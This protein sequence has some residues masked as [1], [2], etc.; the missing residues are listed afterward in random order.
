MRIFLPKS[1]IAWYP[2]VL[3][4]TIRYVVI[5]LLLVCF[6]S[7]HQTTSAGELLPASIRLDRTAVSSPLSGLICATPSSAGSGTEEQISITFPTT[8]VI[9]TTTA[10][11]TT[12][13][14]N[15][16][17][18][19]TPW[20]GIG[21]QA[22]SISGKTVTFASSDLTAMNRYCFTF[23]SASSNT[24]TAS[25]HLAGVIATRTAGGT[26]I[27]SKGYGLTIGNDSVT[28]TA[29]VPAQPTDFEADL[30]K[31]APAGSSFHQNQT[32]QYT[33]TYGSA[34]TYGTNITV[35]AE[36]GLGTVAGSGSPSVDILDYVVGSATEAI[37]STPP[38]IDTVNRTISW[39]LTPM[40]GDTHDQTVTFKLKTN[41]SYTGT[42]IVTFP[43]TARVIGPGTQTPD[44]TVTLSYTYNQPAT[45]TPGPSNTPT[46]G[47]SSSITPV[48][49]TSSLPFQFQDIDMAEISS[50]SASIEVRSSHPATFTVSY[51][52]SPNKLTNRFTTL[53][54]TRSTLLHLTGLELNTPYYFRITADDGSRTVTSDIYTFV[55]PTTADV[56][57]FD[58]NSFVVT[59]G[60]AIIFNSSYRKL[61]GGKASFVLPVGT[62]YTIQIAQAGRDHL[63]R[64]QAVLISNSV[65]GAATEELP[66]EEYV[67]LTEVRPGIYVGQ[68]QTP[69]K[70]IYTLSLRAFGSNGSIILS[71][72]AELRSTG[73]LTVVEKDT[74][75]P[76]EGATIRLSVYNQTTK[77][78]QELNSRFS[79][80]EYPI[81]TDQRGTTDLVLPPGTYRAEV[82]ALGFHSETVDLTIGPVTDQDY[83]V[84]YLERAPF[85]LLESIS[86]FAESFSDTKALS[87]EYFRNL[88]TSSR[89][90]ELV[91]VLGIV[92]LVSLS[93][94]ALFRH[95][96]LPISYLPFLINHTGKSLFKK[97]YPSFLEGQVYERGSGKPLRGTHVFALDALSKAALA[98][99]PTAGNGHFSLR[100]PTTPLGLRIQKQ[101]YL[102]QY[103]PVTRRDG[104]MR[105]E[106]TKDDLP[107]ATTSFLKMTI[108]LG[109]ER[110]I[111]LLLLGSILTELVYGYSFGWSHAMPFIAVSLFNLLYF[112]YY[113]RI[114]ND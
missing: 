109:L 13:T 86:Y 42:G 37:N 60:R 63:R 57:P 26:V 25:G 56:Y 65:L 4:R 18:G 35:Q 77:L 41:A 27:D 44:S 23:S 3:P 43:V 12:D 74:N 80:N 66:A 21:N 106:L 20:P 100:V 1:G 24:G 33:L 73:P 113:E 34:L 17:A 51:G 55:T 36:W 102:T 8:F 85:N 67:D 79:L 15:L 69:A 38:V 48:P 76:V 83:P 29:T 92:F 11:W 5:F 28:L 95:V 10:N 94:V 32:I 46:P 103:H 7:L 14:A 108:A 19:S 39:N 61:F 22:Q 45:P 54:K 82:K 47:T 68:L 59:G 9:S 107:H 114:V 104:V 62:T 6:L 105:F 101:G 31:D 90:L 112:L 78:Y 91:S 49:T 52:T 88:L 87:D 98:S 72:T 30:V 71:K 111:E 2:T 58:E 84:I 93:L 97:T 64:V 50:D 89:Y 53:D 81:R 99:A 70:G 96:G 75:H 40:P 16:P 110:V